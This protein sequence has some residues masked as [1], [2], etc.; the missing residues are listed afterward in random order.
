MLSVVGWPDPVLDQ[1]GHDPRSGYVER[2]WLPI[3]GPSCLLLV[4][5]MAAELERQPDGFEIEST[6]WA[7]ELGIGMKGG[8]H[9]PFWRAVERACRFGAARRNGPRLALR[10]RLPPLSARQVQRLPE[11]LRAEHDQWVSARLERPR[12]AT[13]TQWTPRPAPGSSP[14]GTPPPAV[15]FDDAA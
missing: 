10:R 4:R 2:F 9:G 7:R 6:L 8:Q 15:E 5:R 1:L 14:P 11:S 12:R 3:L 13:V